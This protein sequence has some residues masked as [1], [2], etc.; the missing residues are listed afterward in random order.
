MKT[1]RLLTTIVFTLLSIL[2]AKAQWAGEDKYIMRGDSIK[3]GVDGN[4]CYEWSGPNII[5]DKNKA[6]VMVKPQSDTSVYKVRKIDSCGVWEDQVV[7]YITDSAYILE[8]TPKGCFQDGDTLTTADFKIVT[9]PSGYENTVKISPNMASNQFFFHEGKQK[10]TF[11]L[12]RNGHVSKKTVVIDVINDEQ[13]PSESVSLALKELWKMLNKA[14]KAVEDTKKITVCLKKVIPPEVSP[15]NPDYDIDMDF[16]LPQNFISCCDGKQVPAFNL[17]LGGNLTASLSIN[18]DFDTPY[19]I[20][21]TKTGL[22]VTIGIQGGVTIPAFV[23]KY[24]GWDCS[25]IELPLEFFIEAYGGAKAKAVRDDI[26]SLTIKFVG[27]A[28]KGYTV[29][30][31]KTGLKGG[32][33]KG[34]PVSFSFVVETK[35]FG[36]C[37]PKLTIPLGSIVLFNGKKQQENN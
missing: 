10:V 13:I 25:S 9:V 29:S 15:C 26:L 28:K 36:F 35:A 12:E 32:W 33:D 37:A 11:T 6:V 21:G 27:H 31:T 22:F 18:C 23:I 34:L 19:T 30:I 7:V 2:A 4:A 24:R 8:V 3:I 14:K 17:S 5:S 20:P 16:P 1:V